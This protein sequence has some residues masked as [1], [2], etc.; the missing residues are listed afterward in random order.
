MRFCGVGNIAGAVVNGVSVR[1]MVSH[2]GTIGQ[3]LATRAQ[4][5]SYPWSPDAVCVMHSDGIRAR[6]SLDAYP[7]LTRREPAVI[8]GVLYRDFARGHDDTGIVVARS[9]LD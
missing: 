7:G 2:N 9:R 8:A 6:W 1:H 5:F 4:E 3:G